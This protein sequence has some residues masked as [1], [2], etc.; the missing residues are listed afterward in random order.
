MDRK[1]RQFLKF[2]SLAAAATLAGCSA[3]APGNDGEGDTATGTPT[4]A[5]TETATGTPTE[6]ATE[7]PTGAEIDYGDWFEQT[8]N[9]DGTTV[10]MTGESQVSVTVGAEGNGGAFAFEPPAIHVDPGTTVTWEWTGEGASHNVVAE[11]G[12]FRSGDPASEG[13]TTYERTF[14]SEGLFKYFCEPHRGVGMRGAVVAPLHS[15]SRR[16]RRRHRVAKYI[17]C[18]ANDGV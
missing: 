9:F 13:G 7:T 15:A 5:A 10:D 12:S 3:L 14:D 1:R 18:P 4:D 8:D 6:T 2:G 11:N 17:I 16:C